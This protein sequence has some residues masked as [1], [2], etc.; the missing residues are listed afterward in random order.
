MEFQKKPNEN[1]NTSGGPQREPL[2]SMVKKELQLYFSSLDGHE[3]TSVYKMVMTEVELPIFEAAMEY[4]NG[5][6]SRAARILGVSRSTLRK[7]LKFY[8]LD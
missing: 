3:P 8:G 6:Q 5:N 2:A 1:V 4:V 7:K